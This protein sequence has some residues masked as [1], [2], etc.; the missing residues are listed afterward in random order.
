VVDATIYPDTIGRWWNRYPLA[1]LALACGRS[2]LILVDYDPRHG[3]DEA[4]FWQKI[5]GQIETVWTKTPSGGGHLWF[6][7]P[8][9]EFT[10]S[11]GKFLP[12]IDIRAGNGYAML[13]PSN[14][15]LGSYE[16]EIGYSPKEIDVAACPPLLA[17]F[18]RVRK[19]GEQS[20]ESEHSSENNSDGPTGFNLLKA[21][22]GVP[23]GQRDDQIF[24][25]ACSFR[26]ANTKRDLVIQLVS[27]AALKC[28][29]PFPVA[30]A[31]KKVD[32]VYNKYPPG[33]AGGPKQI[34][35]RGMR[36]AAA[37]LEEHRKRVSRTQLWRG[38]LLAGSF[39]FLLGRAMAGK[40]SFAAALARALHLG[41]DFLGRKCGKVKVG[42]FCLERSGARVAELFERWNIAGEILY[43][44]QI[45]QADAAAYIEE[46]IRQHKL[47]F[48][49]IDH[50]QHAARIKKGNEYAE[51]TN[52]LA[53]FQRIAAETGCCILVL[54]HQRKP[55]AD[56][57][58]AL[59]ENWDR[60]QEDEIEPIG[61][62]AFKASA[63]TLIECT[64]AG[65]PDNP[66]E[67]NKINFPEDVKVGMVDAVKDAAA[68]VNDSLKNDGWFLA[69]HV[70]AIHGPNNHYI[71]T[72][73]V[74]LILSTLAQHPKGGVER[75]ESSVQPRDGGKPPNEYRLKPEEPVEVKAPTHRYFV[76]A[77]TRDLID[78]ARTRIHIDFASGDVEMGDAR[79]EQVDGAV[80][81]IAA[82]LKT[83]G[84][85]N[86]KD[87]RDN[88]KGRALVLNEALRR[89]GKFVRMGAG[90][91]TDPYVYQLRE[92]EPYICEKTPPKGQ[93]SFEFKGKVLVPEFGNKWEQD[94]AALGSFCSQ[95]PGTAKI[96]GTTKTSTNTETFPDSDGSCSPPPGTES[97]RT[98]RATLSN[99]ADVV[100]LYKER[101]SPEQ[102]EQP[103]QREQDD[104]P[105]P[106]AFRI[107]MP[108]LPDPC[109]CGHGR[110]D[111]DLEFLCRYCGC[112]TL[113]RL[114][115][116]DNGE[117][118]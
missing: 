54:H 23:E 81:A 15:M 52:A 9:G 68:M 110:R 41:V 40:S 22:A 34:E 27:D 92:Q 84:P 45:P 88:V 50:L 87:I 61:S 56:E 48:I 12:G 74:G 70:S 95:M 62:E 93:K 55:T 64:R 112:T 96:A 65:N 14:H 67:E 83:N 51:V 49:V 109:P 30:R 32:Y 13:P 31:I 38:I 118:L 94:G 104:L 72:K 7:A 26:N 57:K 99:S 20:T 43:E 90:G 3:G 98:E 1:N 58:A 115:I 44:N 78:L 29:P 97:T 2:K 113:R 107:K 35:S 16:F 11:V 114:A 39:N 60:V 116:G 69:R 25:A 8:D 111:H 17:E 10:V 117:V 66:A 24:R 46:Q 101:P 37:F 91:R 6:A 19:F 82:Y 89:S 71:E 105:A 103:E 42:Y 4:E 21:L 102:P 59:R 36:T 5:G 86:E 79:Q 108:R 47:E 100:P 77:E 76:R 106:G 18:A 33:D 75:R 73:L 28:D 80:A 53:P 63:E 85:Q